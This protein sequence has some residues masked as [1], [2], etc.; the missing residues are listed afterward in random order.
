MSA[1]LVAL[2][3]GMTYISSR[4]T[5]WIFKV[6]VGFMWWGLCF[7]WVK[8]PA[9]TD[10]SLQTILVVLTI[11]FGLACMFWAFWMNGKDKDGNEFGKFRLPF[12]KEEDGV[13]RYVPTRGERINDYA[14]RVNA[15]RNGIR[16]RRR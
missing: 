4:S 2:C 1:V 12:T 15:A 8:L 10:P 6:F 7:Y 3:L 16:Q 11:G 14:Q 5:Y 13:P 9:S